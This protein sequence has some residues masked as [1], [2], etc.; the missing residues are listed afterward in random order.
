MST[1]NHIW[2]VLDPSTGMFSCFR[3]QLWAPSHP[4]RYLALIVST[5][6]FCGFLRGAR[7]AQS[8][9]SKLLR[10]TSL[11]AASDSAS[12][13]WPHG[14]LESSSPRTRTLT[15]IGYESG[16]LL[17]ASSYSKE[18]AITL[19]STSRSECSRILSRM[20][21]SIRPWFKRV[22]WKGDSSTLKMLI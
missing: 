3:V 20:N 9:R 17:N 4:I 15:V 1:T 10:L 19:R 7:S 5:C 14:A 2:S 11:P 18:S 6:V 12:V 21:R 8:S 16:S 22:L 13:S